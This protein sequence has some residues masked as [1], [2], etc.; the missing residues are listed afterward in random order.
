M[1]ARYVAERGSGSNGTAYNIKDWEVL[2][3]ERHPSRRVICRASE[4]DALMI[5]EALNDS[6]AQLALPRAAAAE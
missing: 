5:A 3:R 2:D 4:S 6:E 1:S